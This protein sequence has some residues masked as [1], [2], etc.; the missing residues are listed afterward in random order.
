MPRLCIASRGKNYA[1]ARL[2]EEI[3]V[4]YITI[5][6]VVTVYCVFESFCIILHTVVTLTVKSVI[7]KYCN[8]VAN[9]RVIHK[10][11]GG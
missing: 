10:T 4:H 9:P 6:C 5:R 11:I 2:I 3:Y 1:G 8:N 7:S